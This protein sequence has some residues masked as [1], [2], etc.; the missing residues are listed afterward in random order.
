[1]TGTNLVELGKT[2]IKIS[3]I[4]LGIMQWGDF[5]SEEPD[6][7][8]KIEITQIYRTALETGINFFDTAEM[9]GN[10]KSEI[11]LGHR[12]KEDQ[13]SIVIATKFMPFPWRMTKGELR[14]ALLRSLKRLGLTH[15][16]LYQMHWPLPPVSIA[17]WMGAMADVYADG[18][19]RA[20]GVSNY[21]PYQ[22]QL[23]YDTLAKYNI[24]LASNQVRYSLLSRR[25]ESSGLMKKC[26]QLGVTVIAYSPLEKGILT[27]KYS[28][29]N[30]PSGFR[31]WRYN[32]RYLKKIEPLL[33][34]LRRIGKAHG[35]ESGSQTA[36]NW[37]CS[38]GAV[39]IPGAR[40]KIQVQ[41]N[42]G[43]LGWQMSDEEVETLES[44]CDKVS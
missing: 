25:P 16:D 1:M 36:L 32:T 29:E 7:R 2:G 19:I 15:V 31:A 9:Y 13:A 11:H 39:P 5:P 37:L 3:R 30:L 44:L 41:E 4:G 8:S 14:A 22:T 35:I 28:S 12:L 40:S 38:K 18:L 26:Q 17:S 6:S 33:E 42:A 27:G 20:V 43:A 10:G 34:G 24:P 23:A 21:S